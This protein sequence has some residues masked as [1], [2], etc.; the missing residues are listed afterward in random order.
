MIPETKQKKS[1]MS[2]DR[3]FFVESPPFSGG[4]PT[5]ATL[6]AVGYRANHEECGPHIQGLLYFGFFSCQQD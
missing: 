2:V 3:G 1:P 5:R 6:F 4:G